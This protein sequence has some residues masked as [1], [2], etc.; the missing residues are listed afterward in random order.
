[1]PT[2]R[3]ERLLKTSGAWDQFQAQKSGATPAPAA[4]PA[5]AVATATTAP[6]S[7]DPEPE[8]PEANGAEGDA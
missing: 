8:A 7:A 5:P 2:D 6:T 4:A 1:L 3:V